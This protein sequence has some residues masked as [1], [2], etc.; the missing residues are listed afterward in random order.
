MNFSM[1]LSITSVYLNF[2]W[3]EIENSWIMW[4]WGMGCSQKGKT[5]L[6]L[7]MWLAIHEDKLSAFWCSSVGGEGSVDPLGP[8]WFCIMKDI[9]AKSPCACLWVWVGRRETG[10]IRNKDWQLHESISHS[11][12]RNKNDVAWGYRSP[13]S[14]MVAVEWFCCSSLVRKGWS[15]TAQVTRWCDG[16]WVGSTMR[17]WND[18]SIQI[19]VIQLKA[20]I[21]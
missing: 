21:N 11:Y 5:S 16:Y 12:S 3:T 9:M 1:L 8:S 6:P 17:H 13:E 15:Y 2:I 20:L 4:H 14:T 19:I 18:L 7:W 10:S